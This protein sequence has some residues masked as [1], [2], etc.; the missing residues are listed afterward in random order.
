MRTKFLAACVTAAA[1]LAPT[2]SARAADLGGGLSLSGGAALVSDYR[3]RGISL[4]DE[5]PAVQGTL[6]LSHDSGFYAGTWASTIDDTPVFGDVEVD[7]YGGWAGDV[8]P[9][10]RLDVGLTYYF[11]PGGDSAFG[12]SDYAEPYAKLSHVFGP[13]TGTAGI[14]YAWEQSALGD[15]DN[16]YLFTDFAAALPGTPVTLKAHAGYS[17][18]SLAPTGSYW[19]WSLGAD[20]TFGPVTAGIA[21]VDTDLGNVRTVDPGVIFSLGVAF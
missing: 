16:T 15:R 13:V 18:G 4:S 1:L 14:A 6:T 19:D 20:A 8:A 2:A 10:T 3:F 21:Y 12:N 5:D 11:Y 9:G 17:D 7:F